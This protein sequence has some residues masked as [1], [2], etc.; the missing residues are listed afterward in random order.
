MRA[1]DGTAAGS[2]RL[3]F[4]RLVGPVP[5][6]RKSGIWSA[7]RRERGALQGGLSGLPGSDGDPIQRSD[8][9]WGHGPALA[10]LG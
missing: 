2:M 9:D 5:E 6:T 10:V 8:A 4:L 1:A 3:L 7:K